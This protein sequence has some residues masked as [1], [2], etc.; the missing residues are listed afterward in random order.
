M[1]PNRRGGRVPIPRPVGV[2][3]ALERRDPFG[4][5]RR[6]RRPA[7]RRARRSR[8]GR[9]L[10]TTRIMSISR[11]RMA[12]LTASRVS[13]PMRME[14]LVL[15]AGALE[16]RGQ[17]HRV[18]HGRVV[19]PL[20]RA[21]V[22]DD[23]RPGLNADAGED[24][25]CRTG[26]RA[27]ASAPSAAS[28]SASAARQALRA[29]SGWSSGAF[30]KAMMASPSY[31]SSV[32]PGLEDDVGHL[33]KV[34]VEELDQLLGGE[35]LRDRREAGHVGEEGRDLPS[36]PLPGRGGRGSRGSSR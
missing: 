19:E 11:A 23:G 22:P 5:L 18:A 17:V 7:P 24:V 20:A 30:Q 10:P 34:G 26:A 32:P 28:G 29:W 2:E 4:L 14:Y 15:F 36:S 21:H 6:G 3:P 1:A 25:D 16:P 27:P 33:R 12:S 31:L 8:T 13:S 35:L 9:F